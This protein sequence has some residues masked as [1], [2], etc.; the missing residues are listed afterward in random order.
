MCSLLEIAMTVISSFG[1]AS[2]L[3]SLQFLQTVEKF[4]VFSVGSHFLHKTFL[5]AVVSQE[6]SI[7]LK[8][9]VR[10][11]LGAAILSHL[12]GRLV[13]GFLHSNGNEYLDFTYLSQ[14]QSGG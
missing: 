4:R 11:Q 3:N 13:L 2:Y 12:L 6:I 14:S 9:F 10:N 7:L 1:A 8:Y 5:V